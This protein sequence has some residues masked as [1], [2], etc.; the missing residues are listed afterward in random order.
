MT[1]RKGNRKQLILSK[2]I[3]DKGDSWNE[4]T[5]KVATTDAQ[6]V[7][8]ALIAEYG[9][10][11]AARALD[12]QGLKGKAYGYLLRPLYSEAINRRDE[13]KVNSR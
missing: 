6:R 5:R 12:N 13:S 2:I 9:V 8:E 7:L 11:N 1:H 4:E 10:D 3:E